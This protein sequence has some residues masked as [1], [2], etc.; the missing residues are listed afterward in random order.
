MRCL[1]T[2]ARGQVGRATAEHLTRAGYD[3]LAVSRSEL[4]I[5]SL[6]A[7][8]TLI[9][10]YQPHVVVN[11]AAMTNVDAC[12]TQVD[13]AFAV[14]ALGVRHLTQAAERVDAHLIHLST[15][16]VFDGKIDRPYTEYDTTNPLSVY[17]QSKLGGDIEALA[18]S[19]STT[20]R[21]AWVF[22]NSAGDFFS[23]VL[24]GVIEGSITSLIDDQVGTPTYSRDVASVIEYCV[25]HRVLGLINVANAGETTRL[26][27]GRS[28][29]EMMSLKH[30]LVGIPA[31]SLNRPA[32]RPQYSALSSALL[33]SETA[34]E[35][36]PWMDALEEYLKENKGLS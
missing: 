31:E 32:A 20:L 3:V 33:K 5:T 26:D 30:D 1:I 6:D 35:M 8:N 11:A 18:Y 21:V 24:N 7:V 2:G 28:A 27:M 4:D 17:A 19:R 34:I 12:E 16:F 29:C 22:G 23:W 9:A 36:R 10:D 15:D 14:N 13:E 25:N